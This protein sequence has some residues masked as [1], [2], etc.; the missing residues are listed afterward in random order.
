M[1]VEPASPD[2]TML[3]ESASEE[4]AVK[5]RHSIRQALGTQP[6]AHTFDP[7][8]PRQV[9]SFS[10]ARRSSSASASSSSSKDTGRSSPTVVQPTL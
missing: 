4:Y 2:P 8:S 1:H 5:R 9:E 10:E 3:M 6:R 7:N